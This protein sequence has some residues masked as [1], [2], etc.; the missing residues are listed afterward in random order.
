M[1]VRQ[2]VAI[3][4]CVGFIYFSAHCQVSIC[5]GAISAGNLIIRAHPVKITLAKM[6]MTTVHVCV[7]VAIYIILKMGL[8]C[9]LD[10]K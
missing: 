6:K 5:F 9:N 4:N 8:A 7:R 2:V 10:A 1:P 3:N